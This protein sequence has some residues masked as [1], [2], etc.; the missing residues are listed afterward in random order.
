MY[1]SRALNRSL[2]PPDWL[3]INLTLKCNLTCSMCTTCYDVP[4]ELSTT[5]VLDLIDQAAMW[6]IKIFNPLGGEPFMRPDLELILAHAARKD[7][8]ITLTTN[9]TL[10]TARRAARIATIPPEKL[11]IN[12]SLDGPER[13]HDSIRGESGYRRAMAGYT[14]LR[15]ADAARGNPRRK[16][17]ANTIIHRRN[18]TSLPA[19]LDTLASKGFQGVQLLNLFRQGPA[20]E[21]PSHTRPDQSETPKGTDAALWIGEAQLPDLEKLVGRLRERASNPPQAGFRI[22]NSDHDLSLIPDYYRGQLAPDDAQCWAG[23]K[24]LYINADGQAIMCDGKL[25]FVNGAFGNIRKQTLKQ[26]WTS[27]ELKARRQ[28]VKRCDTPCIQNC[29]LRRESD[30]LTAIG[31]QT[32]HALTSRT[33]SKLPKLSVS[34][35]EHVENGVLTLELSD[36]DDWGSKTHLPDRLKSLLKDAPEAISQC[37]ESPDRWNTWR[38]QSYVDFGRGFMGFEVVRSIVE[39]LRRARLSFD[40]VRLRWRGEPLLHP[41]IEPVLRYL[42]E[43]TAEHA[44][45]R[46]LEVETNGLLLSESLIEVIAAS[47]APQKWV[48]D[49]D[50]MGDHA[51]IAQKNVEALVRARGTQTTIVLARTVTQDAHPQSD[52]D[53]WRSTL[54]DAAIAVGYAP[55][56]GDGIWFRRTDPR[57]FLGDQAADAALK[58]CAQQLGVDARLADT[59]RPRCCPAPFETPTISW[60]AALT[61]CPWDEDLAIAVESVL[62]RPLSRVWR[63]ETLERHR[64]FSNERGVPDAGPCADCH[65]PYSPNYR[66]GS[67]KK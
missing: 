62:E 42:L 25:E 44:T 54:P 11:H 39:D 18:L 65:Q 4:D 30:S 46:L 61:L 13:V 50:R 52:V 29:Y 9:G 37:Y 14:Y 56:E 57:S 17:L 66:L 59:A 34:K 16:I 53:R 67:K 55:S 27:N 15:E 6:G 49:L 22:L 41:E 20:Y 40:T 21:G 47:N 1:F 7:F 48:F 23:W 31:S 2:A 19:F 32:L 43:A 33:A 10:I 12:L 63:S 38:D 51:A 26:L 45:F 3:S 35:T 60:D 58:D 64:R 24:E 28:T 5:E 8:H 36:V